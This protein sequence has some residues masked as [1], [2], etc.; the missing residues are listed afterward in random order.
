MYEICD[1]YKKGNYY[2]GFLNLLFPVLKGS[3]IGGFTNS[4]FISL[5]ASNF[6]PNTCTN[7]ACTYHCDDVTVTCLLVNGPEVGLGGRWVSCFICVDGAGAFVTGAYFLVLG[8]VTLATPYT[9]ISFE[10]SETV[11]TRRCQF[12]LL[13]KRAYKYQMRKGGSGQEQMYL[14]HN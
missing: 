10:I 14:E 5:H 9:I 6:T 8:R 4:R 2:L 12:R 1:G 13:Q 11:F 3:N 7:F